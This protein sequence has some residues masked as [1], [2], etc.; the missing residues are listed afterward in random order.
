MT[1][2]VKPFRK[3]KLLNKKS[4]LTTKFHWGIPESIV[5]SP[6]LVELF[7][8]NVTM[9]EVQ[10]GYELS[11]WS[12]FTSMSMPSNLAYAFTEDQTCLTITLG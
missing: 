3:K 1:K 8:E 5:M 11:T 7:L 6:F 9:L 4:P 12:I 10:T 2:L